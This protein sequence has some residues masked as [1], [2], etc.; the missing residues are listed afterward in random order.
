[1]TVNDVVMVRPGFPPAVGVASSRY[2]PGASVRLLKRAVKRKRLAPATLVRVK[3]PASVT[4][5]VHVR[6]PRFVLVA[7]THAPLFDLRPAT[8]WTTAN[9]TLD[10][11]LSV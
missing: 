9:L 5:R 2:L 6:A 4:E 3:L 11:T 8:D 7:L 1:M 10:A